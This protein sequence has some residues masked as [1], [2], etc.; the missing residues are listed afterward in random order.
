MGTPMSDLAHAHLLIGARRYDDALVAAQ[1]ALADDPSDPEAWCLVAAALYHLDRFGDALAAAEQA[2][3]LDPTHEWP[4]RL[5]SLS[6]L[7]L[8]N[9]RAA[10]SAAQQ[11]VICSPDSPA[12]ND[13]LTSAAL[14]SGRTREA[15]D[16]AMRC[17]QLDPSSAL[18]HNAVARV[19]L[20]VKD[21]GPAEQ[22]CRRALAL[23][24]ENV[25]ARHNLG[26]ALSRQS[27]RTR[28]AVD[29]LTAA[30]KLNPRRSHSRQQAV[31]VGQRYAAAGI[32]GA[33]LIAATA[34]F[35]L[36]TQIDTAVLNNVL[37][38]TLVVALGVLFLRRRHRLNQLP[39]PVRDLVRRQDRSVSRSIGGPMFW[40]AGTVAVLGVIAVPS[41]PRAGAFLV[42]TGV[43]IALAA[44]GGRRPS[45]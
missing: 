35:A 41:E 37:L 7:A 10:L 4:H 40:T 20:H 1:R 25:A 6:L 29:H 11:A 9:R 8:D 18:G 3:A 14:A 31:A 44:R 34:S 26:I 39:A 45:N 24:P 13:V 2:V 19:L 38:A 42:V 15:T 17:I 43:A 36:R 5:R 30:S 33:Y 16:A 12:A 28:E 32:V 27:G 23:D 21:W 22:A